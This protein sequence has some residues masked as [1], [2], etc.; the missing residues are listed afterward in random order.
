MRS[1]LKAFLLALGTVVACTA[2]ADNERNS[3]MIKMTTS[4]GEITIKLN[5][6]KAPATVENFLEYVKSGHYDGL[7][8]HRVIPGFMVQGGGMEPG[9]KER[10]TRAPIQN[11]ADNGL[12]NKRGTLSMARTNDP[13][14]ASSQFFISVKDNSFLDHTGK[15]P[16]G[17]G[18]AVFAE[19]VEGMEVVDKIVAVPTGNRGHH[20]DVPLEDVVIEKAEVVVD[21]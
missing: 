10:D 13:H 17:W 1:I 2:F 4:L 21:E 9:M 8:F 14:S 20:G 3:D 6:E 19:V 12:K 16:Q 7:I 11:E 5:S 18:Y 15:N